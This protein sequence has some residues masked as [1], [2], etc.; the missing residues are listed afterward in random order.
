MVDEE[1]YR[2][3]ER[4][5]RRLRLLEMAQQMRPQREHRVESMVVTAERTNERR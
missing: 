3:L 4:E 2:R 1:E 5:E